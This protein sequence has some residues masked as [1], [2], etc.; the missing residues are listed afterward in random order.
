MPGMTGIDLQDYL[1]RAGD[2][3]PVVLLTAY[4]TVAMATKAMRAGAAEF[5][6]KPVP[7]E[8]L[9]SRVRAVL[10]R[11]AHERAERRRRDEA[12]QC[13]QRLTHREREV[14]AH[15]V[16]GKPNK[17]TALQLELSTKTIEAHRAKIVRKTGARSVAELVRLAQLAGLA[18]ELDGHCAQV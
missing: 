10:E 1:V 15:V 18:D 5:L 13:L 6:E 12:Q 16:A 3:L 9:L 8:E 4:G 11:D 7:G 17:I 14:L 2:R